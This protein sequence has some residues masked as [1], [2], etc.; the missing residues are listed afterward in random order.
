MR[1]RTN[2]LQSLTD[3]ILGELTERETIE[4]T[5]SVYEP[6]GEIARELMTLSNSLRE[7]ASKKAEV[8]YG[9]LSRFVSRMRGAR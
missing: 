2:T 5:A 3:D 6:K 1:D 9:D 4:K 7:M 8:N